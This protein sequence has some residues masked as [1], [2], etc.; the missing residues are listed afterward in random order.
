MAHVEGDDLVFR[1]E[2]LGLGHPVTANAYLGA[3]GI[4]ETT[5]DGDRYPVDAPVIDRTA[6]QCRLVVYRAREPGVLRAQAVT[7]LSAGER[8]ALYKRNETRDAQFRN[9]MNGLFL[10]HDESLAGGE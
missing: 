8:K 7:N 9:E 2:E 3:F 4:A 1:A 10:A 5:S 6:G